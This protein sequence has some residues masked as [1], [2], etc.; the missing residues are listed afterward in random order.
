MKSKT[1]VIISGS[2][3]T[4]IFL[5]CFMS[6]F[7]QP[8]SS[9]V[10]EGNDGKLVYNSFANRGQTNKD[11]IIPDFSW[12]GY[13]FSNEPIPD[14]PVVATL[15]PVEGDNR[16]LIQQKIDEVAEM[17]PDAN[18]FRGAILLKAGRYDVSGSIYI[19]KDGIVLRG[20]GQNTAAQGGTEIYATANYKH[21]VISVQGSA[22]SPPEEPSDVIYAKKATGE[23]V[24]DGFD[25][26]ASWDGA[27]VQ[28]ADKVHEILAGQTATN[29][30]DFKSVWDEEFLYFF[31]TVYDDSPNP[32]TQADLDAGILWR[33]D[34]VDMWIDGQNRHIHV[35]N[36][37]RTLEGNYMLRKNYAWEMS[38]WSGSAY[39]LNDVSYFTNHGMT[40]A[41]I[42]L[43]DEQNN[44]IGYIFEIAIPWIA[45][46]EENEDRKNA[47]SAGDKISLDVSLTDEDV[48]VSTTARKSVV[49]WGGGPEG[50]SHPFFGSTYWGDLVLTATDDVSLSSFNI[51][52]KDVTDLVGIKVSDPA[53]DP[54]ATLMLTEE[55]ISTG[56]I[57]VKANNPVAS[58]VLSVNNEEIEQ[59]FWAS[60]TILDGD[61]IVVSVV[62]EDGTTTAYYKVVVQEQTSARKAVAAN[63]RITSEVPSGRNTFTVSD[64]TGF[65]EGDKIVVLRT[66]NQAWIDALTM[67][68][69][70]W[71]PEYYRVSYPRTI[72]AVEG[73]TITVDVP[74]VHALE[75]QYGGGEIF[76]RGTSSRV[77][78]AGIENMLFSS[79][80]AHDTDEDHA[81]WAIELNLTE[82]CWV[83]NVTALNIAKGVVW[84][85]GASRTTVE[86]CAM[87]D[88]KAPILGGR[89][90]SFLIDGGSFN[91]IQR[92][93]TRGGRHDYAM[94]SRVAGPNVFVDNLSV[95]TYA[96]IGPHHRYATGTLFDN[97]LGGE[98]RVQNRGGSGTGHGW[99]GAQTMFWNVEARNGLELKVSSPLGAM[100]W[101]IGTIG[102]NRTGDG[103]FESNDVPVQP[104]SLYFKQLEDRI[105]KN[106]VNMIRTNTQYNGRIHDALEEW[107]GLGSLPDNLQAIVT[108][109]TI[110]GEHGEIA[111]VN[112]QTLQMV[113]KVLPVMLEDK[114]VNW[115]VV[116]GTGSA[117]INQQGTLTGTGPGKVT[118]TAS[119]KDESGI[120]NSIEI[121]V[122]DQEILVN[123]ILVVGKNDINTLAVGQT[124]QMMA[125]ISPELATNKSIDWTI[126]NETGDATITTDGILT[127][128]ADGSINVTATALDGSGV[129]GSKNVTIIGEPVLIES[130]TVQGENGVTE[131]GNGQTLQFHA[132]IEPADATTKEITWRVS[133]VTGN[134][135]ITD[136]GL[137]TA[138]KAGTVIVSADATDGSDVT[139]S[140]ELNIL[141]A[142]VTFRINMAGASNFDPSSDKVYITGSMLGWAVPG[143]QESKQRMEATE[144]DMIYEKSM[145]LEVE[146][147]TYK[148]A[149][150][151]GTQGYEWQG[152][153]NREIDVTGSMEVE[154]VFG[155]IDDILSGYK[156]T[157][158]F[159]DIQVY[160]NPAHT[161]LTIAS[162]R[163]IE[164]IRIFSLQGQLIHAENEPGVMHSINIQNFVEGMYYINIVSGI[165][166]FKEK[167]MVI[168]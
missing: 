40:F 99:A 155:S 124:L 44:T 96:D 26:E 62:A 45:I 49:L 32:V 118:V 10:Y 87:L 91:L 46:H 106:A 58:V 18:G 15:S 35:G 74:M 123:E 160:P 143:L 92:C 93:Y 57:T 148:Y 65:S 165:Q 161:T 135:T 20:E 150:N 4:I 159:Q 139:G 12:A 167:I 60:R 51:S 63:V 145:E 66:P 120:T 70:G 48:S 146:P 134:A 73:N 125:V 158:A 128:I 163:N 132:D 78:K 25:D 103:Y 138:T 84:L 75:T 31:F 85:N 53:T 130:I 61:I 64:A 156:N 100:N 19:R 42:P 168:R 105:G 153:P 13:K 80:Y 24:I 89:R 95:E 11:N 104:R 67:G 6:G 152:N 133:P 140:I 37:M 97:I 112:G 52:E 113:A 142:I 117:T 22:I 1:P 71:T 9:L 50:K 115:S 154:N 68:Q 82:D 77:K 83:R 56:G 30:A 114:N 108:S 33:K 162:E 36:N 141:P 111:V 5:L 16:S 7:S 29:K 136:T 101:G 147:Y 121:T 14:V 94:G 41:E 90:Y 38:G 157:A 129:V 69:W 144:E 109:I 107:K 8:S 47:I 34:G 98:I 110:S 81:L 27:D 127:A 116:N 149:I 55:Q 164:E 126:D 39:P 88:P 102:S 76:L 59:E 79:Y 119:A 166:T 122:V 137:L 2:S 43:K 3:L 72:T 151:A 54:G 23:I 28:V 131:L 17:Q 21:P 86:E